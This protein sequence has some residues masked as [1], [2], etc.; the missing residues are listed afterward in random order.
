MHS[1]KFH[2]LPNFSSSL[3]SSLLYLSLFSFPFLFLTFFPPLFFFFLPPSS[4]PS[5]SFSL[6]APYQSPSFSFV[7]LLFPS[8]YLCIFATP[9]LSVSLSLSSFLSLA[10]FFFLLSPP[11]PS[12]ILI[13]FLLTR[14]CYYCTNKRIPHFFS[15]LSFSHHAFRQRIM[16]LLFSYSLYHMPHF[17][18]HSIFIRLPIISPFP[19]LHPFFFCF[20]LFSLPPL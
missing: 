5:L 14:H 7:H 6:I 11:F 13:N 8:L 19:Q 2:L 9:S 17:V 4:L 18:S 12:H 16:F 10:L 15:V 1:V 3:F 20:L